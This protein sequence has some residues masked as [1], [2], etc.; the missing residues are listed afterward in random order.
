[1]GFEI[2]NHKNLNKHLDNDTQSKSSQVKKS[3]KDI[4][5]FEFGLNSGDKNLLDLNKD[6][7][8]SFNEFKDYINSSNADSKTL[9]KI[10]TILGIELSTSDDYEYNIEFYTK[11][12]KILDNLMKVDT[13]K[14]NDISIQ[15]LE[16]AEKLGESEKADLYKTCALPDGKINNKQGK[17]GSCWA[18]AAAYGLSKANPELFNKI[19]RKDEDGNTIVTFYGA[20]K[21]FETKINRFKIKTMLRQRTQKINSQVLGQTG[22][23]MLNSK[24]YSS[25]PDAV[26]IELAFEEYS[27]YV[28][29]LNSVQ[30]TAIN[31]YLNASRPS[32]PVKPDID[33]ITLNMSNDDL[34]ELSNYYNN[35][36]CK[37][38]EDSYLPYDV[39]YLNQDMIEKIRKY[40]R[41]STPKAPEFPSEY[42]IKF[43]TSKLHN[44]LK[45]SYSEKYPVPYASIYVNP[46]GTIDGGGEAGKAIKILAGGELETLIS[47][48]G[49]TSSD[50]DKDKEKISSIL[51]SKNVI[52]NNNRIY[53][54]SFKVEDGLVSDNHAYTM[55]NVDDENIYLVNP[56]DTDAEP[57]AYPIHNAIENVQ[58]LQINKFK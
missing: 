56:H 6:G 35:S 53:S 38:K 34:K 3:V 50:S 49:M 48:R 23:N 47:P 30:N 37:N 7:Q 15:E 20:D 33:K 24:F 8:V 43:R 11:A 5:I 26:A 44:Y 9:G 28:E 32:A 27:R 31:K 54:V 25:D 58:I 22:S 4:R 36:T 10:A 13:D 16:N 55:I 19:V 2:E 42:D 51:L 21:P 45:N 52:Q 41:E 57:I 29:S 18:L 46:V 17:Q 14:N 12:N 40:V 39:K 1:M